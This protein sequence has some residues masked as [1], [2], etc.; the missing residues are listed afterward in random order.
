MAYHELRPYGLLVDNT[1]EAWEFGLQE[2][3]EHIIEYRKQAAG[4]PYL[5]AISQSIDENVSDIIRVYSSIRSKYLCNR[6]L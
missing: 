2:K 4:G 5:Y 6:R 1:P 3:V